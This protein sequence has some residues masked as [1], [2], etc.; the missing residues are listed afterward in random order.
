MR[1]KATLAFVLARLLDGPAAASSCASP[2][3]GGGAGLMAMVGR[4]AVLSGVTTM[5]YASVTVV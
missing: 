2:A 5:L 1:E 3:G 4:R